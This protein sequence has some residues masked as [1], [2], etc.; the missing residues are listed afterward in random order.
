[1]RRRRSTRV[2]GMGAWRR[3]VHGEWVRDE[4]GLVAYAEASGWFAHP[5]GSRAPLGPF[6]DDRAAKTALERACH[7]RA[8]GER[9][10]GDLAR[11]RGG[12]T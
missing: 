10:E 8:T 4:L 2:I 7:E 1:M 11:G 12:H 3:T 6:A 5:L 9:D